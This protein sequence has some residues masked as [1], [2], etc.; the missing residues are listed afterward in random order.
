M[1]THNVINIYDKA[2]LYW[3][4]TNIAKKLSGDITATTSNSEVETL[5][6]FYFDDAVEAGFNC[7]PK[8]IYSL[9]S[10]YRY[11]CFTKLISE[12][13]ERWVNGVRYALVDDGVVNDQHV[14]LLVD[15]NG[16]LFIQEGAIVE[17]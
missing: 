9:L 5:S 8:E 2:L 7:R 4:N 6:K 11:S 13:N 1:N 16:I 15:M 3:F 14:E 10:S 12:G 17:G